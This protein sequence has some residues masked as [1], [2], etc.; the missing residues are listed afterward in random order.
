M[1]I[2]VKRTKKRK[3]VYLVIVLLIGLVITTLLWYQGVIIPNES[4]A[5]QYPVKGIDV[6]A[7]Q[8]EIEWLELQEQGLEFAFIKATEGSSFVDK[9]FKKIGMKRVKQT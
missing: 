6:S 8:G 3:L 1:S 2:A 7:Y 9:Y 5:E 4:V